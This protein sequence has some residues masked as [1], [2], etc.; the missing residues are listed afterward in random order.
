MGAQKDLKH[1]IVLF[2]KNRLKKVG[3]KKRGSFNILFFSIMFYVLNFYSVI[4][5]AWRLRSC[6][7]K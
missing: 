2:N 6:S 3:N 4:A 5:F 7:S 1:M